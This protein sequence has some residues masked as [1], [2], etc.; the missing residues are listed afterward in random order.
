MHTWVLH[1]HTTYTHPHMHK[2]ATLRGSYYS[3]TVW[4]HKHV[5][6]AGGPLAKA[7]LC[8]HG[9]SQRHGCL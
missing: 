4:R 9:I 1:M 6:Q 7:D 5:K 2:R 8:M 3:C